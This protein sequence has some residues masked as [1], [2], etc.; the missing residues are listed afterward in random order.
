MFTEYYDGLRKVCNAYNVEKYKRFW[1][2]W[3]TK[4]ILPPMPESEEVIFLS[5]M[6]V[7]GAMPGINPDIQI[8]AREWL[9]ANGYKTVEGTNE[10][11]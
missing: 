5:Y 3:N 10:R 1:K 8:F 4:G 11:N 9:K 7:C 2:K 6:K